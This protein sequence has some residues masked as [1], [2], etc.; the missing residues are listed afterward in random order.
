[1]EEIE[2]TYNSPRWSSEFADCSLPVVVKQ[3]PKVILYEKMLFSQ[4]FGITEKLAK[5]AEENDYV[6]VGLELDISASQRLTRLHKRSKNPGLKSFIISEK[7]EARAYEKLKNAGYIMVKID[8][9][10]PW[11]DISKA[12]QILLE[13]DKPHGKRTV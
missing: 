7:N 4:G 2:H 11:E 1:M 9:I 6:Y 10:K 12:I 5:A 3:A 13:E 8:S